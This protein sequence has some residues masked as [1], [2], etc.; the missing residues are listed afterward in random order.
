[1]RANRHRASRGMKAVRVLALVLLALLPAALAR[2]E[3]YVR[4][5]VHQGA[6]DMTFLAPR[7]LVLEMSKS[8]TGTTVSI[9]SLKGRDQRVSLDKLVRSLAEAPRTSKEVLLLTRDTDIGPVSFFATVL[10]AKAPPRGDTPRFLGFDLTR[11]DGGQPAHLTFPL[12]GASAIGGTIAKVLGLN[13]GSDMGP[14]LDS[15]LSSA[16][17]I[18]AGEILQIRGSDADILLTTM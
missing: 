10:D 2:A 14:F 8:P 3:D 12:M 5:R 6:G 16:K 4:L 15:C 7:Q 18:G 1:M 13:M 11:K 9:G 17:A